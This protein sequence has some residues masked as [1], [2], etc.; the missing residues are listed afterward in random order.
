MNHSQNSPYAQWRTLPL[1]SVTLTG[2]MWSQ[3]QAINRDISLRHGYKMLH[4]VGNFHDLQ[5]A[6][7]QVEGKFRGLLFMDSDLYK[8]LEAVGYELA[9]EPDAELERMAD[10]AI[11]LIAAAQAED[12]YLN[13]FYQVAEPERR[14]VN[15]KDGHELYCF[16]HLTEAAIVHHRATGDTRLLDV[17]RK[18][19]AHID[20]TFGEGKR[21]VTD[22]H[23]ESELALIELYRETGEELYLKMAKYLIDQRGH[24]LLGGN[25]GYYQDRV[26]VRNQDILEGHA[27][28]AL[29]LNTGVTDLYLETGEPA[30]LDA[31]QNQWR[32]LVS[33]KLF[34]T[35]GV[36]SRH[37]GE[38][39]GD[40]Y[41]L[42]NDRCYCETCAAIANVLWNW[43]MLQV[44]GEA[45]FADQ[46]ERALYNGFLSGV[47]LN[48]TGFFYVN[49]LLSRGG[50]SRPDWHGCACCPPNVMRMLASI[51]HYFA[52]TSDNGLQIQ[53][54][55]PMNIQTMLANG[56]TVALR[57]ET[58]YPW[59]GQV[60]ITVEEAGSYELKL[61]VPGWC[62]EA[63]ANINGEAMDESALQ[64]GYITLQRDWLA[65]DT[66]E[67]RLAMAPRLTVGNPRIDA[68]RGSVA[69]EYGPQVYC[70]EAVDNPAALV[71]DTEIDVTAPLQAEW[72]SDLLNGVMV[73]RAA[74]N[75]LDPDSWG[76]DL[77][78][79]LDEHVLPTQPMEL[80]AVPYQLWANRDAGA[81]RVW[82]PRAD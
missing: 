47:S 28:R 4:E 1:K 37:E 50:Y 18:F 74:G 52:T 17:V 32:D 29:Y 39:F 54:F 59:H 63:T 24:R 73:I 79:P 69:I 20:A 78:R 19:A 43:R 3:R 31:M 48:G 80:T 9:N 30:L 45:R 35:G 36:G 33:G 67:L 40:P 38:A 82:I 53:H 41:E 75:A 10:E 62:P 26:P 66:I 68:T 46:M 77:Y 13:S 42:P 60:K 21:P 51:T 58:E 70:I 22:G 16:G 65:G 57:V 61:R 12:G 49:P 14:W 2:G 44:T 11:T 34:I 23:P 15:L 71:L 27:V 56:Q 5:V 76:A 81:M 8:W 55:A 25:S 7:G 64:E 72:H 6:A